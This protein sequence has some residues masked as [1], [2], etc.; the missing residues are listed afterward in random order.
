M[1]HVTP[2][3]SVVVAVDVDAPV[4]PVLA[5]AAALAAASHRP[6]HDTNAT[7]VGIVHP[8]VVAGALGRLRRRDPLAE[9]E[10]PAYDAEELVVSEMM[11]GW[12]ERYP[13]VVVRTEVLRG[14]PVP[15][16][17]ET[18]RSAQLLVVGSRGRGGFVGL[19][20]GG[21]SSRLLHGSPCPV[22][23]VPSVARPALEA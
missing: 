13:D 20:L 9:G 7:G 18:A 17:R 4:E 3:G 1:H 23:V 22:L 21:V 6:L 10:H 8:C 5:A 19:L 16:L 11:V 15:V 12:A 2:V 14:D